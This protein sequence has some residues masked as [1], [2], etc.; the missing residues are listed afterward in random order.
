MYLFALKIIFAILNKST[1]Y[2][3]FIAITLFFTSFLLIKQGLV[4]YEDK[5]INSLKG[6]YPEFVTSSLSMVKKYQN[7][8]DIDIAKEIF[9]YS[10]EIGFSYGD[11]VDVTKFMNVRTFDSKHKKE[12]FTTL[13][14]EKG[15]K[16]QNNTIYLSDRLYENMIKDGTFDKKHLY[17][18]DENEEYI[19]YNICKFSLANDEKW[20]V[21]STKNGKNMAYMPRATNV[22]YT[23]NPQEKKLLYQEKKI[24]TWKDYIDYD[25][26][27]IFLLAQHIAS[28]FLI[29]FFLFL[30]I[31]MIIVFSSLT[32]EFEASI[33]LKK[34]FGM[35]QLDTIFLYI[36][37]FIIYIGGIDI[38][39]FLE[40]QGLAFLIEYFLGVYLAFDILY[41]GYISLA[42]LVLGVIVSVLVVRKYHRLPL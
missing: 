17:F 16:E 21:T 2:I 26:L 36:L 35:S 18:I 42:L 1:Q 4:V 29:A 15:C 38:F 25:D 41:L 3:S 5:F 10:Q 40:Y 27:G 30:A 12:L 39:V 24:H 28:I 37:F 31:F 34:I 9:V 22:L 11:G 20:L 7:K 19:P 23:T 8:K 6:L 13:T 33:F 32:K 14:L